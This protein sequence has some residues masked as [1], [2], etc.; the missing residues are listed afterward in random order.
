VKR[1]NG[2][3]LLLI[4][5]FAVGFGVAAGA[6]AY[7]TAGTCTGTP[8][9][10]YVYGEGSHVHPQVSMNTTNGSYNYG[11]MQVRWRAGGVDHYNNSRTAW[12]GPDPFNQPEDFW[13]DANTYV[14]GRWWHWDGSKWVLPYG[15]WKCI[16]THP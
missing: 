8:T 15:D 7:A 2:L 16:K 14:C 10:F 9:C 11:H 13:V 3:R 12:L 6:P 4:V 1:R 5:L